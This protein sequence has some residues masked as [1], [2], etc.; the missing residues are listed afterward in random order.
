MRNC[1]SIAY[2]ENDDAHKNIAGEKQEHSV[3][4]VLFESVLGVYC[5]REKAVIESG[6]LSF[7]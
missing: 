7:V 5:W 3:V 1:T 2:E 6:S 4:C